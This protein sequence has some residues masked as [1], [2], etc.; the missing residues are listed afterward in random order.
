MERAISR[1]SIAVMM[2]PDPAEG[3]REEAQAYLTKYYKNIDV[4]VYWGKVSEFIS[5][6]KNRLDG[7]PGS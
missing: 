3:T 7:K 5:E 6:L 4:R 1:P 2:L